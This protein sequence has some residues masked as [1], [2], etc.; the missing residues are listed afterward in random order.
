M[1]SM[2][3]SSIQSQGWYN[4]KSM[5]CTQFEGVESK[6]ARDA[7]GFECC[8]FHLN[9]VCDVYLTP[10]RT[11]PMMYLDTWATQNHASSRSALP[12]RL[13]A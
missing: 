6:Q 3:K 13:Q 1:R 10:L 5:I 8:I 4:M 12:I 7:L 9:Y 11:G 2:L